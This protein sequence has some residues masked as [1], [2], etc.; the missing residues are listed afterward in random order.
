MVRI[1][2]SIDG[3]DYTHLVHGARLSTSKYFSQHLRSQNVKSMTTFQ[4]PV[5][6]RPVTNIW[7][8][9]VYNR[10][11]VS[12]YELLAPNGQVDARTKNQR[13]FDEYFDLLACICLDQVIGDDDF[14]NATFY[15]LVEQVNSGHSKAE[16]LKCFTEKVV[17]DLF[18]LFDAASPICD[19]IINSTVLFASVDVFQSI[20]KSKKY[21]TDYI[22]GVILQSFQDMQRFR[23]EL[24]SRKATTIPTKPAEQK[25]PSFIRAFRGR[26]RVEYPG[27]F[28]V[29]RESKQ[30]D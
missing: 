16:L 26:V 21:P 30:L 9:W 27:G 13:A 3:R 11:I 24:S 28:T 12:K 17:T 25:E 4:I 6:R 7:Y 2:F 18:C 23:E 8:H 10:G 15:K 29:E 20:I 14:K 1:A 19:M 22:M 5:N